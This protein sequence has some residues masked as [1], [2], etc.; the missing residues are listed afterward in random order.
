MRKAEAKIEPLSPQGRSKPASLSADT[1]RL[2]IEAEIDATVR[3]LRKNVL[4]AEAVE[5]DGLGALWVG[6][7]RWPSSRPLDPSAEIKAAVDNVPHNAAS[8]TATKQSPAIS[9]LEY[10]RKEFASRR[11]LGKA[12]MCIGMSSFAAKDDEYESDEYAM[13]RIMILESFLLLREAINGASDPKE[14]DV[15][16]II[17]PFLLVIRDP[18]ITGPITRSALV[19]IQRFVNYGVIDFSHSDSGP[20]L[21]EMA[22]AVTHCRFEATDAASDE[23]VLMQI[24]NV[25]ST[26]VLTPGSDRLNDVTICEIMESVL[27]I[28]CQM[29]LSEMLRRSAETTLFTLVTFVFGKL[30]SIQ[31]ETDEVQALSDA[32]ETAEMVDNAAG[33]DAGIPVD[34]PNEV[35]MTMPSAS[36]M[37]INTDR[38]KDLDI[39]APTSAKSSAQTD[40]TTAATL[41][42]MDIA[43]SAGIASTPATSPSFGLPAIHELYRAL[44][45]LTNPRDLQYTDSMRLLALNTLQT[46]FQTAGDAM[47]KFAPLRELTLGDLSRNLLLILQR[48]QAIL[49]SPALRVLYLLFASHRKDTKGQLELFLCQTFGRIMTLPAIERQG[50]RTS[51]RAGPGTS[52]QVQ[53][54]GGQPLAHKQRIASESKNLAARMSGD[55]GLGIVEPKERTS[56]GTT[57]SHGSRSR[58]GSRRP[59][60]ASTHVQNDVE[61]PLV[62]PPMPTLLENNAALT[63]E[64]EIELYE[65][66]S[67]RKGIRGR[68]ARHEIRRQLLEGL[69]HFLIGDES[70]LT[71]LWVNYDCDMQRGNMYDFLIS[72][73]THRAVPWPDSPNDPED[74]AFLDIMLHYLI[75]MA[76][77]AGVGAPQGKLGQLLGI[78]QTSAPHDSDKSNNAHVLN[79]SWTADQNDSLAAIIGANGAGTASTM[80]LTLAQ[81]QDRKRH[82]DTMM[83]AAQLFNEK[84]KEGIAYLQ[85]MGNLTLENSS[86]MT[87]QL[88]RFFHETPTVNKKLLGEYLAKPSNLEVLQTYMQLFDFSGKRLDEA[89]RSLLGAFRLP[90]ESQQIERI[91]EAFSAAYFASGQ[92][93]IAIKDAAFILAYAVIMLNT[94]QHSRQ[95]KVRMKFDD[96]AHNLRGVNDGQDFNEAFLVDVYNAI[97]SHE[98]IFPEEHEGEAGFEHAWREIYSDIA[99]ASPWVSTRGMTAD[100]DRGLLMASWPRFLQSIARILE[101]FNSDHTLRL[102]L[103]GLSALVASAA[104]YGVSACVDESI[105]LLTRLTRVSDTSLHFDLGTPQIIAKSYNRYVLVDPESPT[106]SVG[107]VAERFTGAERLEKLQEQ[108]DLSFQL[109][110]FPDEISKHGWLDVLEVVRIVVDA[111]ILPRKMRAISDILTDKMWVPRMSTLQAMDA[112]QKRILARQIGGADSQQSGSQ[113]SGLF[114]AISSLWGGGGGSAGGGYADYTQSVS[115]RNELRWRASPELLVALV[116]RS[117]AAV[118]ASDIGVLFDLGKRMGASLQT[119]LGILSQFF[120]QP[121]PSQ[122]GSPADGG[123]HTTDEAR[124]TVQKATTAMGLSSSSSP[125]TNANSVH[126][127]GA[128]SNYVPSSVF[129]FELAMSLISSSPA[130]APATWPSI[131]QSVQRML[132]YAD[133]LHTF[134]LERTVGGLLGLATKI[135]ESCD[136]VEIEPNTSTPLLDVI[137]RILRCLGL[138]RDVKDDTFDS[139]APELVEGIGRLVDTDAKTLVSVLA[140]WD[141][142]RLLI[143]R[144]ARVQDTA[145]LRDESGDIARRSLGVLVEI[146]IL[147]RC[148]AV[149]PLVYFNDVLETLAAFMPSDRAFAA[150]ANRNSDKEAAFPDKPGE[151]SSHMS[152][153]EASSKL[154]ALLYE[155][156]DIAKSRMAEDISKLGQSGTTQ[157]QQYSGVLASS[158]P[159]VGSPEPLVQQISHQILYKGSQAEPSVASV[160]STQHTLQRG[161][162]RATPLSMWVGAMNA[163]AAYACV[164][165]REVRQLACSNI[166]RAASSNLGSIG[167][168]ST[169]FHRVLFPLMDML[170]RADLLADSA[171]EDTHARCISI[172]TMFFLHN[173]NVLQMSA[174]N[175]NSSES[176]GQGTSPVPVATDDLVKPTATRAELTGGDAQAQ[177]KSGIDGTAVP[178]LENVWLRLIGIFAVYMH[179]SRLASESRIPKQQSATDMQDAEGVGGRNSHLS[180]LGEMAEE[181]VKNC[182]LVLD[183]MGIFGGIDGRSSTADQQDANVLWTKTWEKLDK[184]DPQLKSRIFPNTKASGEAVGPLSVENGE[185]ADETSGGLAN[186]LGGLDQEKHGL[187]SSAADNET[188]DGKNYDGGDGSTAADSGPGLAVGDQTSTTND[189][190]LQ[191]P[192][193][194]QQ[195]QQQQETKKKKHG[196]QNI[197]IVS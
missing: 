20:A 150:H 98:I 194:Q 41:N 82:K 8:D 96:F 193:Q 37:I 148:G 122:P 69:H 51:L 189:K 115:R 145:A 160:T 138:L 130:C 102:A 59:S 81:L 71:D 106:S 149:D 118:K 45:E 181:S 39:S 163:L 23:S 164:G 33:S 134:A 79:V 126:T 19:S 46:A 7:G 147:L 58:G 131:E 55:T 25:L 172:L 99:K 140:N 120:P 72:F 87:Q 5:R 190:Q 154:V 182:L 139:V 135:L 44:V 63:Y 103:S 180:V 132:E 117:C 155:M 47:S 187:A 60:V 80:P 29:R 67:L 12:G 15:Q 112:A 167:W 192:Q 2:L 30:N 14:M 18:E 191:S 184:V 43:A 1:W 85:R 123:I 100:Y 178:L 144:L 152:A 156:Q 35:S 124:S 114:S 129:F 195:E 105:R 183:S 141:I 32:L 52:Q 153:A 104:H 171:M 161:A 42:K 57:T 196:R 94:D 121:P 4:W 197:I 162:L 22:R 128:D 95:V 11:T 88:A 108:E 113:G 186:A 13:G 151:Q 68:I 17:D 143:K 119:F 173:A 127:A 56:L 97:K 21:L 40:A 62:T 31:R 54:P 34:H 101:H 137:E 93:D 16:A 38:S 188:G 157:Q 177:S 110:Q 83:R 166:Q 73:I 92:P 109:T 3:E 28:S 136:G 179:T 125:R 91:V 158:S 169:A 64:E 176:T 65:N 90:G 111:D 75:R 146:V 142:I 9:K 76:V 26:L 86:E 170:L 36:R 78:P 77:R 107:V 24:L 159:L 174:S 10:Y 61:L 48:D 89:L 70:L 49:I 116:N 74:E 168:I 27:S 175:Y 50:S 185:V 84:P 66:A 6:G 53:K 133:V 165:N